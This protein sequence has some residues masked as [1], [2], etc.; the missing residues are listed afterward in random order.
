MNTLCNSVCPVIKDPGDGEIA[1]D[2]FLAITCNPDGSEL[3]PW[4]LENFQSLQTRGR[5]ANSP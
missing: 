5:P 1:K 3:E 4:F 2:Q